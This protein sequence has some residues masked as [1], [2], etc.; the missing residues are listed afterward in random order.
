MKFTVS[1]VE[2]NSDIQQAIASAMLPQCSKILDKAKTYLLAEIPVILSKAI[3]SQPEYISLTSG[4]LRLELGI[5]DAEQRVSELINK[6][7]SSPNINI[8]GPSIKAGQIQASLSIK[9]IRSNFADVITLDIAETRDANTGSIVP[10][11]RWLLLDGSV[12]LVSGYDVFFG[13][14]PRSRTGGA[15]MRSSPKNWSIPSSFSGT[16]EDNWITRAIN[17]VSNDIQSVLQK[18][19]SQ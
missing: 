13:P 1:L 12:D 15:I 3:L 9:Y 8:I 16:E 14:N 5:P 2:S 4:T 18:A 19:I 17:S 10:W 11:L 6:W 7:I